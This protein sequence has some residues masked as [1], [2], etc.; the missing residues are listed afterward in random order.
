MPL[1]V[2]LVQGFDCNPSHTRGTMENW[3]PCD[4]GKKAKSD[5][6]AREAFR[7]AGPRPRMH[8]PRN[9]RETTMKRRILCKFYLVSSFLRAKVCYDSQSYRG[10]IPCFMPKLLSNVEHVDRTRR[11]GGAQAVSQCCRQAVPK[12][13]QQRH[14]L[15]VSW[16]QAVLPGLVPQKGPDVSKATE[17]AKRSK[18]ST[19]KTSF[20][21]LRPAYM[22]Q[23]TLENGR[24]SINLY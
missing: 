19:N 18:R 17:R 13:G 8:N 5:R 24:A 9:R 11:L 20:K 10:S 22:S 4:T 7:E 2:V 1:H 16:P 21:E 15:R 6:E 14:V 23:N 3:K 12:Q